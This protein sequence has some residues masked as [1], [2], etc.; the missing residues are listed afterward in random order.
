M[1]RVKELEEKLSFLTKG[2]ESGTSSVEQL[3]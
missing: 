2:A 1:L 3:N